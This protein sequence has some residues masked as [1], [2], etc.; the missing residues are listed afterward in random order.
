MD[1]T[2][3]WTIYGQHDL[4]QHSLNL[5]DNCGVKTLEEAGRV[6]ILNQE[7]IPLTKKYNSPKEGLFWSELSWRKDILIWHTLTWK[8]E[9]P[10]PGCGS[11]SAKELLELYPDYHLIVTGDNHKGFVEEHKGR[12]LVNPGCLMRQTA[13]QADYKPRVYL[14]YSKENEVEAVYLPINKDVLTRRHLEDKEKRDERIEAFVAQLGSDK[15]MG[16]SFEANLGQFIPQNRI[17]ESV[18]NIIYKSM[19]K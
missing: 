17:R 8:G 13:D 11:P 16:M 6:R 2:T 7:R 5:A 15:G 19:G 9:S 12:L 4:P 1:R 14:W 18:V 3:F 10:F